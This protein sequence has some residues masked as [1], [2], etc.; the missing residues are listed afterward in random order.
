[1]DEGQ[2]VPSRV[3][4]FAAF[5]DTPDRIGAH[6]RLDPVHRHREKAAEIAGVD[7]E[8]VAVSLQPHPQP[9]AGGRAVSVAHPEPLLDG[10]A[11]HVRRSEEHT[12]ELQS[13][14]RNSYAV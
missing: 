2:P 13:L 5:A 7:A 14:M 11:H 1:M 12:S 4:A 6:Q 3:F 10:F 8:A 9:P